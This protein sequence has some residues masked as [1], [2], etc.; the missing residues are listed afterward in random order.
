MLRMRGWTEGW[1]RRG[2]GRFRG[3]TSEQRFPTESLGSEESK[4]GN[5]PGKGT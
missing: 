3:E 2:R 4:Y 5:P 1:D